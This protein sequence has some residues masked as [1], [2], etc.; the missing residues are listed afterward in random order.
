MPPL[1]LAASGLWRARGR[2]TH[3]SFPFLFF[4]FFLLSFVDLALGCRLD[5]LH[6]GSSVASGLWR[7]RVTAG[8]AA[9]KLAMQ[10][11]GL[12][13]ILAPFM[14]GCW[15]WGA[16]LPVRLCD[17]FARTHVVPAASAMSGGSWV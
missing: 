11:S 7:A 14:D 12:D 15:P 13:C 16:L 9:G 5:C 4:F 6:L 10:G 2:P 17:T 3:T 8:V 1:D